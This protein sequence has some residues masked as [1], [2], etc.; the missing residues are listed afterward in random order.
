MLRARVESAN[1]AEDAIQEAFLAL[2][3]ELMRGGS[4]RSPKGLTFCVLRR[5]IIRFPQQKL[6]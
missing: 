5:Q 1:I 3:S 4:V 6:Q 2:Y